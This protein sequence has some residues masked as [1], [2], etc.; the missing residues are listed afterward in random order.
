MDLKTLQELEQLQKQKRHQDLLPHIYGHK[1]YPWQRKFWNS[2]NHMNFLTAANQIGKSSINIKKCI[3]WATCKRLWKDLWP[4]KIHD[5]NRDAPRMFWYLYPDSKVATAEFDE[6]WVPEFLPRDEYKDHPVYGWK[7][8]RENHLVQSL[9]FNSGVTIY[10]KTYKQNPQSLQSGTVYSIFCDEE[11]PHHLY[12][13]LQM[14]LSN[15]E[16]YFHMVFTATLNQEVWRRTME[17]RDTPMEKFPNA[18]KQQISLYDCMYFEDGSKSY[19]TKERIQNRIDKCASDTEVQ[20]RIFG[21][22]VTEEGLKYPE[23]DPAK[24]FNSGMKAL[25]KDWPI[26]SGVDVGSGG[27]KGHPSAIIFVAVNPEHTEGIVWYGWRGDGIQTTASDVLEKYNRLVH[28]LNFQGRIV[29]QRYDY[30]DRDFFT[31]AQRTGISFN[32]ANKKHD[33]GENVLNSLFKLGAFTIRDIPELQPLGEELSSLMK[34]QDKRK[35]KDD[36][37]DALRYTVVTIP[38]DMDS[39]TPKDYVAKIEE[40]RYTAEEKEIMRRRGLEV[41]GEKRNT[42][43]DEVYSEIEMWNELYG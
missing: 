43:A 35:A 25:P 22:F 7:V 24:H 16:G 30:K 10:F 9:T 31:I 15:T 11:L 3:H 29:D 26:Y 12:D 20:R 6:K 14:R 17:C 13:E 40:K 4:L 37:T 23:F 1:M 42:Y 21:R 2:C 18:F 33:E 38:W 34:D 27:K 19:W 5:L 28:E 36:Y 41:P 8:R 39:M 32:P